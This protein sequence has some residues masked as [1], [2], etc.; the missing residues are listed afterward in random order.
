MILQNNTTING[1]AYDWASVI[2][3]YGADAAMS[4]SNYL[5]TDRQIIEVTSLSYGETRASQKNYGA[6]SYPVTKGYG[7][8]SVEGKMTISMGELRKIINA[9]ISG[10]NKVQ[11]IPDFSLAVSYKTSSSDDI[12]VTDTIYGCSIDST[13][14]DLK[15][16]D[17]NIE[18]EV[19]LNPIGITY[20]TATV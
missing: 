4:G 8:V 15:Q 9:D 1:V 20:G 7:N 5:G 17:M 2:L 14:F 3:T 19:N 13:M 6:G 18:V 16:N 11:N 12:T 10:F